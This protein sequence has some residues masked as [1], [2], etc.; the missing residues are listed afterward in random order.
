[1]SGY[2]EPERCPRCGQQL[3][4]GWH[5]TPFQQDADALTKTCP[6]DTERATP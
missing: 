1:M 3:I 4:D 5:L 2:P 6:A